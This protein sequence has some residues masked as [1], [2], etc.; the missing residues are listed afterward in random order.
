[1][2]YFQIL[3]PVAGKG[4]ASQVETNNKD[5]TV[6]YSKGIG[7]AEEYTYIQCLENEGELLFI[8]CGGDGTVNEVVN[9]IMRANAG[10]RAAFKIIPVGTGNDFVRNFNSENNEH[11]IDLIKCNNRYCVNMV[12]I[13][14]DCDVVEKVNAL[15]N[16]VFHG[17]A[18]YILGVVKI[19]L[20]KLGKNFNIEYTDE[21]DEVHNL[22]GVFLL[23][24]IGN[25]SYCGGGFKACPL[26]KYDDGLLDMIAVRK[27]SRA[28]FVKMVGAYRSGEYIDT[29]KCEPIDSYK[30]FLTFSK[31][32]K[33]KITGTNTVCLD[34]EIHYFNSCEI[35]VAEKAIKYVD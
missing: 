27:I 10:N 14:F 19:L 30:S 6:Y 24:A 7:D 9:G 17:S 23:T 12:N 3:N 29:I 15:N 28:K 18:A 35:E 34:G 16:S 5:V 4:E 32:K 1:M 22:D 20:G 8:V 31:I 26:A 13:G 21:N 33:Y 25:G 11:I 2:K